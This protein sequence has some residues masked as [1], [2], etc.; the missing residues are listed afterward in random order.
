MLTIIEIFPPSNIH[1]IFFFDYQKISEEY[2]QSE[3]LMSMRQSKLVKELSQI[4]PIKRITNDRYTI[5]NL[6]IPTDLKN[7]FHSSE[8]DD[9]H[10][11]SAIGYLCH[12]VSMCS[13]FISK[14]LRY[15][16]ICNSSRSAI[17]GGQNGSLFP[18][19]KEKVEKDQFDMGL[20]L[21]NRNID[22]L[23]LSGK[24]RVDVVKSQEMNMLEKLYIIYTKV[25]LTDPVVECVE[26]V[27]MDVL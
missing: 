10:I 9:P 23:L 4:Y 27:N 1:L 2:Q 19:F 7:L 11:S 5:R 24:W 8:Y 6:E 22:C 15:K 18:L 14:P 3:F 20:S 13:K 26:E 16:L 25:S 17:Q 21:L 12:A